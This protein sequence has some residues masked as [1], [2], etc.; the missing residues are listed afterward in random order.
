MEHSQTADLARPHLC[1]FARHRQ[2]FSRDHVR[3]Y[4]SKPGCWAVGLV[5][6]SVV[7]LSTEADKQPS[8]Y[9]QIYRG[10]QSGMLVLHHMT[11]KKLAFITMCSSFLASDVPTNHLYVPVSVRVKHQLLGCGW[12]LHHLN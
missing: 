12:Y 3:P 6:T 9:P 8:L 4:K 11:C 2:R 1:R 7:V 5:T 10:L